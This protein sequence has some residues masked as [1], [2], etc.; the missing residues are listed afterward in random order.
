MI[1]IKGQSAVELLQ[2][3]AAIDLH[4]EVFAPGSAATTV[5]AHISVVLWKIDSEPTYGVA[6]FR[7]YLP[8]FRAWLAQTR[9]TLL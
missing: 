8:D 4:P 7:T 9:L 2:R 6:V 1:R 3:G 5:I